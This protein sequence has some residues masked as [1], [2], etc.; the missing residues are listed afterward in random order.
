M[1]NSWQNIIHIKDIVFTEIN[2]QPMHQNFVDANGSA[3]L[4][5]VF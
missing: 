2:I 4:A 5:Y 3:S 1:Y